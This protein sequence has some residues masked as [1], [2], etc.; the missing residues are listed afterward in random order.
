MS[1]KRAVFLL[2]G[3]GLALVT[4]AARPRL[5]RPASPPVRLSRLEPTLEASRR[6]VTGRAHLATD[7]LADLIE[8]TGDL[9][10][11]DLAAQLDENLTGPMTPSHEQATHYAD[12]QEPVG[13]R[14][15]PRDLQ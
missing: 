13:A 11:R 15:T 1:C 2:R 10:G 14:L 4:R 8:S 6:P 12:A 3:L 9:Q 7:N 5:P